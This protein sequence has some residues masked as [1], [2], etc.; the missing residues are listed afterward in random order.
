MQVGFVTLAP[1]PTPT[2]APALTVALTTTEAQ[3]DAWRARHGDRRKRARVFV[4]ALEHRDQIA[5]AKPVCN[6]PRDIALQP[7]HV[8]GPCHRCLS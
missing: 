8:Y 6:R 5:R 1:T 3:A 7:L 2:L 4:H